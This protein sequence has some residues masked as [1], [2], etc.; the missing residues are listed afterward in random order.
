[1]PWIEEGLRRSELVQE[2]IADA[3]ADNLLQIVRVRGL[4][5]EAEIKALCRKISWGGLK[6]LLIAADTVSDAAELIKRFE[7]TAAREK[8]DLEAGRRHGCERNCWTCDSRSKLRIRYRATSVQP[9]GARA[10]GI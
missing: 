5:R 2:L 4:G 10:S 1:M 6:S 9:T 7:A 3:R 8:A